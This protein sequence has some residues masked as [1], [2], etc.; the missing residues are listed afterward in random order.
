MSMLS[1]L[2]GWPF[3]G[4]V[5]NWSDTNRYKIFRMVQLGWK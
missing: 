2:L 4:L 5:L 3:L 1:S